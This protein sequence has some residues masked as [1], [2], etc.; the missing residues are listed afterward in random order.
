MTPLLSLFLC[1]VCE[2][3]RLLTSNSGLGLIGLQ[4]SFHLGLYDLN[5]SRLGL[6]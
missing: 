3:S 1:Q 5:L 4:I 2:D 6:F